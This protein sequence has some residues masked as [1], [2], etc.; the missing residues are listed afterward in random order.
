MSSSQRGIVDISA[1]EGWFSPLGAGVLP[2]L[3]ASSPTLLL[4]LSSRPRN[5]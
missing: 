3:Y 4:Y 5:F 1:H 2:T